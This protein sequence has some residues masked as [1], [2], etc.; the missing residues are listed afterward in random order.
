MKDNASESRF[1]NSYIK[2]G[3]GIP[4]PMLQRVAVD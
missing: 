2:S 4:A 1:M 3:V